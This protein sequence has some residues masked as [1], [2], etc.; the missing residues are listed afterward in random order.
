MQAKKTSTSVA[1]AMVT[2][3]VGTGDLEDT[4]SLSTDSGSAN[5]GKVSCTLK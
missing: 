1:P 3:A 5:D 2:K 4:T